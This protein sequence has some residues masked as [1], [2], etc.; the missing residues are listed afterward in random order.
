MRL[1]CAFT[2]QDCRYSYNLDRKHRSII[3]PYGSSTVPKH[4]SNTSYIYFL[5]SLHV[6]TNSDLQVRLVDLSAF[7]ILYFSHRH[8]LHLFAFHE[9]GLACRTMFQAIAYSPHVLDDAMREPNRVRS[10]CPVHFFVTTL[11]VSPPHG[12]VLYS[13]YRSKY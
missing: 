2:K 6:A 9:Y 8:V 4:E 10:H 7:M 3:A 5:L 1:V 11:P 12:F 13:S